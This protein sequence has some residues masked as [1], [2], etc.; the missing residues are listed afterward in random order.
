MQKEQGLHEMAAIKIPTDGGGGGKW[1]FH[2]GA[3]QRTDGQTVS[4]YCRA[5]DV[6]SLHQNILRSAFGHLASYSV[7]WDVCLKE[8]WLC[9]KAPGL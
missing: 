1:H 4:K 5:L 2:P 3:K 9:C 7:I 6:P 8:Q